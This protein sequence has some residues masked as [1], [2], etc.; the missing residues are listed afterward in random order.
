MAS[1][2]L[3]CLTSFTIF[4]ILS[5]INLILTWPYRGQPEKRAL[6]LKK[7]FEEAK[8]D[9]RIQARQEFCRRA[10]RGIQVGKPDVS[11]KC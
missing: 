7:T 3:L 9:G 2:K 11:K 8:G 6:V 10:G 4:Y 5:P 1:A